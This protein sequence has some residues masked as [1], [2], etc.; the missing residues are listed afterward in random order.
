MKKL[1]FVPLF[2]IFNYSFA[3]GYSQ[4]YETGFKEGFCF[5]DVGCVSP[6]PPV[7]P[8][9]TAGYDSYQD[10][11]NKGFGD[12][13][14]AKNSS[15]YS[16][17]DYSNSQNQDNLNYETIGN[18]YSTPNYTSQAISSIGRD[19][20]STVDKINAAR[21]ARISNWIDKP[22][23]G[24]DLSNYEYLILLPPKKHHKDVKRNL[25]KKMKGLPITYVN[26]Q[27]P[28][29]TH[30]KIPKEVKSYPEKVLYVTV[31]VR[32][33]TLVDTYIQLYDS[34]GELIYSMGKSAFSTSS[35]FK[36]FRED[37]DFALKF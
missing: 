1:L 15:G 9:P 22:F 2:L 16:N 10:G 26:V 17:V 3:Q 19:Y 31:D 8:V 23:F 30:E 35:A 24:Q 21:E 28:N 12:G 25:L 29:Q 34:Y 27:K 33:T 11:Y 37:L 6:V 14:A 13:K 36:S 7:A 4:G 18:A 5:E 32:A 20:S